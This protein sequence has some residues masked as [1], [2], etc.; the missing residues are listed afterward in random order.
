MDK[1]KLSKFVNDPDW[2]LIEEIFLGYIEPL[3]YIDDIDVSDNATGVKAEIRTRRK[4][5]RQITSFL[6][7]IGILKSQPQI[8]KKSDFE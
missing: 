6:S 5:Y 1:E 3:R 7:E 2:H 8:K 4:V